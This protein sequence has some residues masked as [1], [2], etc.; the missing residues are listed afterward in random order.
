MTPTNRIAENLREVDPSLELIRQ[1]K[2][3]DPELT[4]LVIPVQR[5]VAPA[6]AAVAGK[7][8]EVSDDGLVLALDSL[9]RPLTPA[10]IIGME[11]TP[12]RTDYVA[13]EIL[14]TFPESGGRIVVHCVFGGAGD[15]ILQPRNLTPRFNFDSMSFQLGVPA[16]VLH[17]WE[18]LGVLEP[19]VIDR[20]LLCPRCH[21]LPTFRHGCRQCGSGRVVRWPMGGRDLVEPSASTLHQNAPPKPAS[22]FCPEC[23]WIGSE[24]API[25][26]C[27]HCAHRFSAEDAYEMVLQGYHANRLGTAIA[28]QVG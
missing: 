10:V 14:A 12:E 11:T 24:L 4:V 5:D 9:P 7:L 27:L 3:I 17:Q 22:Y 13:A 23:R 8:S 21:G 16:D 19:V 28:N 2:A 1:Y 15:D 18:S 26:Q 25:N 20:L 6:G